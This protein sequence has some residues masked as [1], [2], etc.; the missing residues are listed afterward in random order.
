[1]Y[2]QKSA[3]FEASEQ[4]LSNTPA[5]WPSKK[6]LQ[7]IVSW[8]FVLS[9]PRISLD[10]L[11]GDDSRFANLLPIH[12]ARSGPSRCWHVCQ[13]LNERLVEVNPFRDQQ[14][15]FLSELYK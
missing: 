6:V 10:R 2:H 4:I 15:F 1:M 13:L 11:E 12:L 8:S 14:L 3:H 5:R 9:F 7:A